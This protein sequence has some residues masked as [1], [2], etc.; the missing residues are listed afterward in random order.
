MMKNFILI[1]GILVC[2]VTCTNKRFNRQTVVNA[3]QVFFDDWDAS[4]NSLDVALHRSRVERKPLLLWISAYVY[5]FD[6]ILIKKINNTPWLKNYIID[7]MVAC[8]LMIDSKFKC[9]QMRSQ[10]IKALLPREMNFKYEGNVA[11]WI[12]R[13]YCDDLFNIMVVVDH[14]MNKY[15]DYEES[16]CFLKDSLAFMFFL[17][18]AKRRYDS[19]EKKDR[20]FVVPKKKL[21]R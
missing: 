12:R 14:E 6:P 9:R 2:L 10:E 13:N 8:R 5:S 3:D 17:Q 1:L 19:L 20:D 18:E 21:T 4:R 7:S 15:S 16:R 11:E